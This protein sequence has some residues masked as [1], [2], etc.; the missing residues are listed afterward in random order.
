MNLINTFLIRAGILQRIIESDK[1]NV[2][3]FAGT[4]VIDF[5]LSVILPLVFLLILAFIL[6]QRYDNRQK[7]LNNYWMQT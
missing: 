1:Y 4:T 3:W 7:R 5:I 2:K 6:K